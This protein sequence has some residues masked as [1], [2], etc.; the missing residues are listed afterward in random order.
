MLRLLGRCTT[1]SGFRRQD[2]WLLSAMV[3][4]ALAALA[5]LL[6]ISAVPVTDRD[7]PRFAQASRQMA[8]GH[9]LADWVVPRVG[10][11]IR[12]KKPPLIYWLQAPT[13]LVCSGGD[14]SHDAI[15][16]YRFPSA[17]MALIAA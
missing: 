1:Q 17:V 10:D 16:M 2:S 11:E 5:F 6:G 15:W 13:A 8:E 14:I 9:T 4:V 12:L 7:E 3:V